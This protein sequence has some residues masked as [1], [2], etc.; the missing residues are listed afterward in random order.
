MHVDLVKREHWF[1]RLASIT[2]VG[3]DRLVFEDQR[4]RFLDLLVVEAGDRLSWADT[5]EFRIFGATPFGRQLTPVVVR[6]PR[7]DFHWI[8]TRSFDGL[9]LFERGRQVRH[10]V[11]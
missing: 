2:A 1:C 3:F 10:R 9:E 5:F 11:E 7:W 6:T 4:K 8:G